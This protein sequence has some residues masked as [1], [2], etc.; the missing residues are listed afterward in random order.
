MCSTTLSQQPK[1][2]HT[3]YR[4]NTQ[5]TFSHTHPNDLLKPHPNDINS[6]RHKYQTETHPLPA[7]HI[8]W[9]NT[10]SA[11]CHRALTLTSHTF[12]TKLNIWNISPYDC[13]SLL[14]L[15]KPLLGPTVP[16]SLIRCIIQWVPWVSG[17][18]PQR[19]PQG[20]ASE[21]TS[22]HLP[23]P[24]CRFGSTKLSLIWTKMLRDELHSQ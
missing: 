12:L 24:C 19:W 17:S 22:L 11:E 21:A 23:A 20:E 10:D 15:L 5:L 1:S 3:Q 9:L 14:L 6:Q 4:L 18:R 16:V 7:S 8:D 13:D 2:P